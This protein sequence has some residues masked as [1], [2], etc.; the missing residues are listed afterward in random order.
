MPPSVDFSAMEKDENGSTAGGWTRPCR[1][2]SIQVTTTKIFAIVIVEM[3]VLCGK[4]PRH[5]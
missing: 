3:A 1:D 5:Y 2:T 4:K